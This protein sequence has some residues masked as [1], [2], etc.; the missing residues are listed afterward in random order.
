MASH[1]HIARN[2]SNKN[3]LK[4]LPS[5]V[6]SAYAAA[7]AGGHVIFSE[8]ELA[9]LRTRSGL[10]VSMFFVFF[11]YCNVFFF[12]GYCQIFE[13]GKY[14]E[15]KTKVDFIVILPCWLCLFLNFWF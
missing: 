5:L 3:P 14:L 15:L 12:F 1:I 2:S 11:I 8:T 4:A 13:E 9:I 6:S 10:P 7:V